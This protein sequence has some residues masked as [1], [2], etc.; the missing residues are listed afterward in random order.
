MFQKK[1][2]YDII[3]DN[4][5]Q[6]PEKGVWL[7][8]TTLLAYPTHV[9]RLHNNSHDTVCMYWLSLPVDSLL[10]VRKEPFEVT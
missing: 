10:K 9:N 6:C 5:M 4:N 1:H 2:I 7:S 8:E 3:T